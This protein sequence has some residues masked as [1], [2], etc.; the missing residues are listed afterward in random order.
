MPE[1]YLLD[2]KDIEIKMDNIFYVKVI[3][4]TQPFIDLR[5]IELGLDLK[6]IFIKKMFLRIKNAVSSE[7]KLVEEQALK[8]GLKAFIGDV[9]YSDN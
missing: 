3:D 2:I 1:D 6:S 7:E 9:K 4:R 8:I 5:S